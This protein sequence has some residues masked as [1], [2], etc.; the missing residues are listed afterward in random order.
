MDNDP[1]RA[2][3][4]DNVTGRELVYGEV[5]KA[6]HDEVEGFNKMGIWKIVPT[7]QRREMAGKEPIR[8]RWVDINKG[9]DERREYRS[10]YVAMEIRQLHGGNNYE[11][12]FAAMPPV[13]ALKLLCYHSRSAASV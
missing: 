3:I 11:G 9:D 13:E 10:R 6:R 8:G 12:L 1:N 7:S 2:Q 4:C 5:L